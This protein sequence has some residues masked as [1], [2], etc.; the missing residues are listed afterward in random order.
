VS[1][2]PSKTLIPSFIGG[3]MLSLLADIMVRLLPCQVEL[4]V[5]VMTA[6]IGS[7]FFIYL[8]YRSRHA[9]L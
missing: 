2:K 3:G 7:P 6:L 8:L 1:S 4:K 5:G 9:Q